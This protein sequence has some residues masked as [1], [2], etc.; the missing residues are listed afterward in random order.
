LPDEAAVILQPARSA[1]VRR[2]I[3]QWLAKWQ[4][5][6][7]KLTNWI[8]E[9]VEETLTFIGCPWRITST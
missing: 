9:N 2:D 4:D 1:E 5:K 3:A 7:P 8:E 6:D